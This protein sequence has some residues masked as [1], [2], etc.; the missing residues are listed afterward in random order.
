MVRVK[1]WPPMSIINMQVS[2]DHSLIKKPVAGA[3]CSHFLTIHLGGGPQVKRLLTI[4]TVSWPQIRIWDTG[5]LEH[6]LIAMP[7]TLKWRKLN[8]GNAEDGQKDMLHMLPAF[9][10][11]RSLDLEILDSENPMLMEPWS[12]FPKDHVMQ[13]PLQ[14]STWPCTSASPLRWVCL[15]HFIDTCLSHHRY[16]CNRL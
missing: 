13:I 2:L 10:F 16:R 14:M 8:I 9:L 7:Q 6:C 5:S 4:L 11:S 15:P 12:L 1:T 3:W